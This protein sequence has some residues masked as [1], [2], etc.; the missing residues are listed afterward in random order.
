MKYKERGQTLLLPSILEM[1]LDKIRM[2]AT[3]KNK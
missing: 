1:M 3:A 2:I